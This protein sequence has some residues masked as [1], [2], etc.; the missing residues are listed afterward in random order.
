MTLHLH[1]LRRVLFTMLL[2]GMGAVLAVGAAPT[3]AHAAAAAQKATCIGHDVHLQGNQHAT[4]TCWQWSTSGQTLTPKTTWDHCSALYSPTARLE[5]I[6]ATSGSYCFYGNGY[7]GLTG[8]YDVTTVKS[9]LYE[10]LLSLG[11]HYGSG[12]VM[13]YRP[14]WTAGTGQQ[15]FFGNGTS[16]TCANSIFCATNRIKITQVYLNQP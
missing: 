9:L 7:L 6:S 14:P 3:T 4:I 10:D 11:H 2:L 12:W 16:Y 1:Q 13:Y 5:I 15:F 8:I